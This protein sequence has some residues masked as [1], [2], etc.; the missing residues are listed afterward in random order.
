VAGALGVSKVIVGHTP[1][2]NV[3][4]TCG[5]KFLAIDSALGRWIRKNGNQYCRGEET[6][7]SKN[8]RYVCEKID[9]YCDGQIVKMVKRGEVRKLASKTKTR[10]PLTPTTLILIPSPPSPSNRETGTFSF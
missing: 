4:V 8:G 3:R 5:D 2:D 1:D 10:R 9:D 6:K 7:Y